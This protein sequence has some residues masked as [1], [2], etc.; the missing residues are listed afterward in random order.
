VSF[1]A[2]SANWDQ[3]FAAVKAIR[4]QPAARLPNP[5]ND[6]LNEADVRA[7]EDLKNRQNRASPP[8]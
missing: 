3:E 5:M 7:A 2:C 8:D 4:W 1:S 6:S